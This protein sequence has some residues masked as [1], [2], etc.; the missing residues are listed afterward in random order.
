[1]TD[2]ISAAIWASTQVCQLT[3]SWDQNKLRQYAKEVCWKLHLGVEF[4]TALFQG[5]HSR[6]TGC[7]HYSP[8]PRLV[9]GI[10]YW[11]HWTCSQQPYSKAG[12]LAPLNM[13]ITALFK[14][15]YSDTTG[16]VHYNPIPR[17]VYWYHWMCSLQSYSKA[18]ILV[19]PDTHGSV[20]KIQCWQKCL[21]GSMTIH[22]SPLLIV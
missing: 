7:I 17:L 21:S 4:I 2:T 15:W 14:G 19:S 22:P 12:I 1:M 20:V 5:W 9:S 13:F 8:V 11:H 18:G 16:H 10:E 6:T 3:G